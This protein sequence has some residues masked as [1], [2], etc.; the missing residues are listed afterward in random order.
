[1][2][3]LKVQRLNTL[4]VLSHLKPNRLRSQLSDLDGVN[5]Q[6]HNTRDKI[7]FRVFFNNS[8]STS[9][10]SQ[11]DVYMYYKNVGNFEFPVT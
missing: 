2:G 5:V 10:I 9:Q 8:K 7:T 3:H 6:S 11:Y 4:D 1:M